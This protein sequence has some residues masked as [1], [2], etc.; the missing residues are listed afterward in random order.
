[1]H[2]P[3]P[4]PPLPL[5]L[6]PLLA[7]SCLPLY[8]RCSLKAGTPSIFTDLKF[9]CLSPTPPQPLERRKKKRGEKNAN[10]PVF[11]SAHTYIHKHV[12]M[13]ARGKRAGAAGG[14]EGS[15]GGGFWDKNHLEFKAGDCGSLVLLPDGQSACLPACQPRRG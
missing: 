12:F 6:L 10:L 15:G 11:P 1:M 3:P 5:L 8:Q 4:A 9:L 7:R 14:D 13:K 2:Q